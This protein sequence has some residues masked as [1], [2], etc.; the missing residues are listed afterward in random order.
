MVEHWL[1]ILA[2]VWFFS[3]WSGYSWFAW[4]QGKVTPCLASVL[5]L[6]REDW[7][8]RVLT[9]DNL[10]ADTSIIANLERNVSFFASTAILIVAGLVTTLAATDEAIGFLSNMPMV[11][12]SSLQLWEYKILIMIIIFVYAFFAFTWSLRQYNFSSVLIGSAPRQDENDVSEQERNSF[13]VRSAKVLSMAGN[14]FNY[15]LRSFYFGLASLAWFITPWLYMLATSI[16]VLVL[17][18]REFHS[19]VLKTMLYTEK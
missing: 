5:H 12:S 16:V 15:G 19:K 4:R 11:S 3:I 17:Y 7:M 9:R 2:V 10:I 14:Q 8:R 13:A 18:Q 6:Y 1:D